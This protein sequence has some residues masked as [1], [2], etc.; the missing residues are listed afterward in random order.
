[1]ELLF[2]RPSTTLSAVIA[3]NKSAAIA[4]GAIGSLADSP[5][6]FAKKRCLT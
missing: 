2:L 4:L 5:R 6:Q 1:M 3:V